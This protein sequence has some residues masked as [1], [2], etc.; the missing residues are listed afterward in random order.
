MVL[1]ITPRKREKGL[2]SEEINYILVGG[3]GDPFTATGPD[4]Q[5]LILLC[6]VS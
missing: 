6:F 5:H 3:S 4:N 1:K 2:Q